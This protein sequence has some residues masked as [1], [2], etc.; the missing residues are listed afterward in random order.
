VQ[1]FSKSFLRGVGSILELFPPQRPYAMRTGRQRRETRLG[2]YCGMLFAIAA[3]AAC[4]LI[5]RLAPN[6]TG[7]VSGAGIAIGA[8]AV[9][10]LAFLAGR[11]GK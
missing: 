9:L 4:V 8:N 5:A 11:R 6:V 3:M 10:T 1:L 7:A 2:Q